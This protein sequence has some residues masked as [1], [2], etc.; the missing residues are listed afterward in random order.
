LFA[1]GDGRQFG[2]FTPATGKWTMLEPLPA[3]AAAGCALAWDGEA[4]FALR[5]EGSKQVFKYTPSTDTW[6]AFTSLSKGA[7]YGAAMCATGI[8]STKAG[9]LYVLLGGASTD[10]LIFDP[11]IGTSGVWKGGSSARQQ[12]RQEAGW[13]IRAQAIIFMPAGDKQPALSGS[14]IYPRMPGM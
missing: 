13:F 7:E 12:W 6:A 9:K 1:T 10:F 8:I 14:I 4:V 2:K 11:T 3:P 5:G